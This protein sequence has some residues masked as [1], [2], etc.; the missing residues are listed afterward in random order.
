M[1][2]TGIAVVVGPNG[3]GKSNILDGVSWVLG[4]QS[5]KSLRGDQMQ[6]IIFN[7]SE[8]RK[9][10][11]AAEVRLML[12]GVTSIAEKSRIPD[13]AD[14]DDLEPLITRDVEVTRRLY[15]SGESEYLINGELVR[16]RDVHELMMDTGLGA[17]AYAIIEQGKIGQILSTR[18][19]DR[20]QLIEEAAGV[21]KYKARRR[22]AELKL[23]A[24]EQNLTRI[25]DI[26]FEVEKQRSALKRQ[27]AKARR[28]RRLREELRRFEKVLFARRYRVLAEEIESA[29]ARL[30]ERR[31]AEAV[32]AGGLATAE[33]TLARTRLDLAQAEALA[34]GV[35]ESA[36]ARE[37][38]ID[39]RQNHI[40]FSEQQLA[41]LGTRRDEIADELAAI[42]AKRE[43]ARQALVERREAAGR[44]AEERERASAV[45]AADNAAYDAAYRG[46]QSLES[47]VDRKRQD[48]YLALTAISSLQHAIDNAAAARQRVEEELG[49]L[50]AE[51]SDVE[52]EDAR[53]QA[54]LATGRRQLSDVQALLERVRADG[55][56]RQAELADTREEHERRRQDTRT[57][58]QE[59][60]SVDA[61]L[62]SLEELEAARA[63]YGDAAR[64]LLADQ[65]AG[66]RQFGSLADYLE[67]DRGHER[68]VESYLGDLLQHVLVPDHDEAARGLA[69][70]RQHN[71]GRC[72]FLVVGGASPSA[73]G[74][75]TP[76]AADL[77][78]M[79]SV[80]RIT[81]EHA[82]FIQRAIGRAWIAPSFAKAVSASVTTD[83]P[84]V[85]LDG[86]VLRGAHLVYGGLREESRGILSTKREI[87]EL[88][89]RT[90]E[91]RG[92]LG[93][94]A[95]QTA[96]LTSTIARLSAEIASLIAEAHQ[97]EKA[98]VGFEALVAKANE[99]RARL[100]RKVDVLATE[101][102]RA[103]EERRALEAREVEARAS[104]ARQEEARLAADER[105]ATAQRQFQDAREAA[106]VIS[107]RVADA[108]AAHAGLVER[109]TALLTEV[110]RQQDAIDELES[111]FTAR[112]D[113]ARQN[114]EQ[115][116]GLRQAIED[117]K[118]QLDLD[119]QDLERLR[120]EIRDADERLTGLRQES[121]AEEIAIRV[122]RQSL[123]A[124][125]AEVAELD[126][127]RATGE[128]D[129][130]HL[131]STCVDAVQATL[132]QVLAE[133]EEAEREGQAAPGTAMVEEP[134]DET[135]EEETE[136]AAKV[137]PST[138][139]EAIAE[140]KTKIDRLGPVNMMAIEQFDELEARHTFL[141]AQRKDLR[142][143]I[144]ATGEA[145]KLIDETSKER[146]REAFGIINTNFQETFSVLFG[147]GRAG[148]TLLD[149]TDVLESG[150][151]IVAQPP[152]KRLQNVQLL[153][154]GEKALTAIALMFGI[155]RYKPSPFC[156]LDEIDAPLDDANIGRFVE[157]LKQMQQHTQFIII[158]HSR[159]TMEIADRL[160]GVTMEEPGV[161]KLISVKL[162]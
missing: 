29:R 98:I 158:T 103:Q 133:V 160:Y 11:S 107:R 127:A 115:Q 33:A 122:S 97:Q 28:Y 22:T 91:I 12:T 118:R 134:E 45:L 84:V 79:A 73:D 56:A 46:L 153:S 32:V 109:A 129:L 62:T 24:A 66:I 96:A 68:A 120:G 144:A 20:R 13:P 76:P 64:F 51:R 55:E 145:I 102:A 72:G 80:V 82:P 112:H 88:R 39:R 162:N 128:S 141:T 100:T 155:F 152:G 53:L 154:G 5:A 136:V 37:M 87:K 17:K 15:R 4:E 89:D 60:A 67:V 36:H 16:L 35:R 117:G 38:E 92:A 159:K 157:I 42:E 44:A 71:A 54:D 147:G 63:Q 86:D 95:E 40:R 14:P 52:V 26:I 43:P 151:E 83:L 47:E 139:D 41:G 31:E 113:E 59:L 2:G 143:S 135:G 110:A 3:C 106:E 6:D 8:G 99:N 125:R 9:A 23:E 126:L 34:S 50:E 19:T 81:G 124:L 70:V 93:R 75:P 58:E 156:V 116:A 94:L 85:T 111:R 148:L 57:R 74:L 7:G 18:A 121:D 114:E 138:P 90:V 105:L 132:D 119:L 30:A 146:F 108:R 61:R 131:A 77:V 25:D 150:I 48:V 27:A 149:E 69:L 21:T 161:S 1:P 123:D 142:E 49:R 130:A 140:L 137:L 104:V 78:P 65:T 101:S 10:T